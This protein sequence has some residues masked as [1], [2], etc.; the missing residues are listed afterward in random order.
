LLTYF[1]KELLS[2]LDWTILRRRSS[3]KKTSS[4][5]RT[6]GEFVSRLD[7][8]R[9]QATKIQATRDAA[10][11]KSRRQAAAGARAR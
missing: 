11:E 1:G 10:S 3:V 8:A 5:P 2:R 4:F 9:K 7:A 6:E